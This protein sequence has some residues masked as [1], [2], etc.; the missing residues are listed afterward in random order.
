MTNTTGTI[1]KRASKKTSTTQFPLIP[2]CAQYIEPVK[3]NLIVDSHDIFQMIPVRSPEQLMLKAGVSNLYQTQKLRISTGNRL[4][5]LVTKALHVTPGTSPY[6]SS[7]A[8][9]ESISQD[10]C[11]IDKDLPLNEIVEE[12]EDLIE[13]QHQSDELLEKQRDNVVNK[14]CK[15][16]QRITDVLAQ[17]I[18]SSSEL[19]SLG[20][21]KLKAAD[22][23]AFKQ[24]KLDNALSSIFA[25]PYLLTDV[26]LIRNPIVYYMA[27]QYIQFTNF[28]AE[29]IKSIGKILR[30]FPIYTRYLQYV[31]GCGVMMSACILSK[32]NINTADTISKLWS[33]VGLDV[34]PDGRGRGKYAEHLVER[35]YIDAKG[36]EQ[37]RMSTTYNPWLKTKVVG[38]LGSCLMKQNPQYKAIYDGYKFRITND[39]A[40]QGVI[41]EAD[42]KERQILTKAHAH[43]MAMRYMCKQFLLDYWIHDRV[44]SGLDCRE[45]YQD[46]KLQI[47][48]HFRTLD[49]SRIGKNGKPEMVEIYWNQRMLP[50]LLCSVGFEE[51]KK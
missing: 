16:F 48:S 42:G 46:E 37:T 44:L 39:P 50:H 35:A 1:K 20:S 36:E 34:A 17:T 18:L 9:A 10:E 19:A 30:G 25:N 47:E 6:Q 45:P 32:V 5:A 51:D 23:I 29:Q 28:E 12:N 13:E 8:P 31:R 14:I 26:E 15:E 40:R 24:T 7:D 43:R 3:E 11:D 38:V 49:L 22:V 27:R 41:K 2:G 33:Y 21:M 4:F